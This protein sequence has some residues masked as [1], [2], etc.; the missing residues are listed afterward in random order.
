MN[1]N[2][3]KTGKSLTIV[4]LN[5]RNNSNILFH[6]YKVQKHTKLICSAKNQGVGS[7]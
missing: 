7:N 4:T 1:Y 2:N 3:N 6:L 5:E